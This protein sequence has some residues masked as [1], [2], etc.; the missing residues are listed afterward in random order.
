[1]LVL[2]LFLLF[3]AALRLACSY[4]VRA[5]WYQWRARP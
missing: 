4:P 1:M 2:V 3:L 5:S